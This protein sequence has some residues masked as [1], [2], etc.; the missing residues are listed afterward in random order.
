MLDFEIGMSQAGVSILLLPAIHGVFHAVGAV[1][2]VL[3]LQGLP[4][5][6]D[7]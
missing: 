3:I 2:D 1:G 7:G 5:L 6:Q 4:T